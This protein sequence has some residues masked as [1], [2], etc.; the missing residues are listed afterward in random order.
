[1]PRPSH[2]PRFDHPNSICVETDNNML[3]T[4][5]QTVFTN[6]DD[7]ICSFSN[8]YHTLFFY[9]VS[10]LNHYVQHDTVSKK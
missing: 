9:V 10:S 7:L 6:M 3:K 5:V 1:M 4:P 2:P 8:M